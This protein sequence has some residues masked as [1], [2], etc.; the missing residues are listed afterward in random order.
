MPVVVDMGCAFEFVA[1]F[2]PLQLA[3]PLVVRTAG[4][5]AVYLFQRPLADYSFALPFCSCIV[6]DKI[7][8]VYLRLCRIILTMETLNYRARLCGS[9]TSIADSP[10]L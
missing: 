8:P 10:A 3:L 9:R 7:C 2:L 4:V 1:L 6:H 5:T